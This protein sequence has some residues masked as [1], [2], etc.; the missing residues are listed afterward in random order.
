MNLMMNRRRLHDIIIV[1]KLNRRSLSP[2]LS[3]RHGTNRPRYTTATIPE[4]HIRGRHQ[5]I[6][7]REIKVLRGKLRDELPVGHLH[8]VPVQR[9]S[10]LDR[11]QFL[12]DLTGNRL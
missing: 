7:V 11:V 8:Q 9:L 4:C 3:L 10:Q 5:L 6:H 1:I 12:L 2:R